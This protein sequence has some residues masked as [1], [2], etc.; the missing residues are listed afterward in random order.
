MRCITSQKQRG[1]QL[2][3]GMCVLVD[4]TWVICWIA[5]DCML[6]LVCFV[7]FCMLLCCV[8]FL[9]FSSASQMP[10]TTR[11]RANRQGEKTTTQMRRTIP[12]L[13]RRWKMSADAACCRKPFARSNCSSSSSGSSRVLLGMEGQL[14]GVTRSSRGRARGSGAALCLFEPQSRP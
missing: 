6:H 8:L 13:Q 5:W 11:Q 3:A 1:R 2:S 9:F 10:K 14:C 4:V 7:D 12:T